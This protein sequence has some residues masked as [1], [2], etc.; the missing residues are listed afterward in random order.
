MAGMIK[1]DRNTYISVVENAF[2]SAIDDID[3]G[4][5]PKE[6]QKSL[7]KFLKDALGEKFEGEAKKAFDKLIKQFKESLKG[8][9]SKMAKDMFKDGLGLAIAEPLLFGAA[10]TLI[11]LIGEELKLKSVDIDKYSN[12]KT[13]GIIELVKTTAGIVHGDVAAAVDSWSH[14]KPFGH[15]PIYEPI[16]RL[17]KTKE[18]I[19]QNLDAYG[20]KFLERR[21]KLVI[22]VLTHEHLPVVAK[23]DI[24]RFLSPQHGYINNYVLTIQQRQFIVDFIQKFALFLG[25]V[26]A[27]RTSDPEED[28][29]TSM[30]KLDKALTKYDDGENRNA[31]EE[32][33]KPD[34]L[35]NDALKKYG[36]HFYMSFLA[37]QNKIWLSWFPEKDTKKVVFDGDFISTF[38]KKTHQKSFIDYVKKVTKPIE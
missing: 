32:V 7:N 4:T 16:S 9:T 25:T 3:K 31:R 28:K 37:S 11:N 14:I 17:G 12:E 21:N 20:R 36:K 27:V 18:A 35:I 10:T 24:F 29:E 13:K 1:I 22:S 2:K 30:N 34:S 38:P 33:E 19:E 15:R 6:V 5:S 8:K 23:I 26:Y